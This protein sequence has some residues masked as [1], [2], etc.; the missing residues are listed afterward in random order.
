MRA[1]RR[2]SSTGVARNVKCGEIIVWR[3]WRS[4]KCCFLTGVGHPGL[5]TSRPDRIK[6]WQRPW[7]STVK[8]DAITCFALRAGTQAGRT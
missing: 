3:L 6:D 4:D 7:A 2:I 1:I 8:L 5:S